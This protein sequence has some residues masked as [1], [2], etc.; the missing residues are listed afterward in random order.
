MCETCCSIFI[1]IY[2]ISRLCVCVCVIFGGRITASPPPLASL[3]CLYTHYDVIIATTT[4]GGDTNDPL[5]ILKCM[6]AALSAGYNDIIV[7]RIELINTDRS[8]DYTIIF[9]SP[10]VQLLAHT[11]TW[12][13]LRQHIISHLTITFCI[14]KPY[15]AT[16]YR[17]KCI[18]PH[19]KQ[20]SVSA[21]H[22]ISY[23]SF[24]Q[25]IKKKEKYPFSAK[26]TLFDVTELPIFTAVFLSDKRRDLALP[27]NE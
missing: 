17:A 5:M 13:E 3:D 4:R 11:H 16:N 7:S 15:R 10:A 24:P 25:D 6:P 21:N 9:C 8:V 23:L 26:V 2:L 1:Y 18:K 22:Y 27:D 12:R 19:I 20:S 14:I